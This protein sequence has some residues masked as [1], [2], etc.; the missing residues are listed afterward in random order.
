MS[1]YIY[2]NAELAFGG[3]TGPIAMSRAT[4][5]AGQSQKGFSLNFLSEVQVAIQ[6]N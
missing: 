2:T 5:F 1:S 4:I 6:F 3:K